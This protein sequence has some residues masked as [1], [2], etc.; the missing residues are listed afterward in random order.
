MLSIAQHGYAEHGCEYSELFLE[1]TDN[2]ITMKFKF[3]LF[4]WPGFLFFLTLN[5]FTACISL[6]PKKVATEEESFWSL[7][8]KGDTEGAKNLFLGKE[9]IDTVDKDGRTPLHAACDM[10]DSGLALFLVSLGADTGKKDRSGRYPLD[11]AMLMG[12]QEMVAVL[13]QAGANILAKGSLSLSPFEFALDGRQHLLAALLNNNNID[14]IDDGQRSLLQIAVIKGNLDAVNLLLEKG[15]RLDHRDLAEK[16][17]LD[18]AF[19][20]SDSQKHAEIA[21]RLILAG[22]TSKDKNFSWFIPA[23]RSANYNV[24]LD[25]SLTPIHFAARYGYTGYIRFLISG[26]ADIKAKTASGSTAL[27]EALRAGKIPAAQILID[28]GSEINARDA[29]GN[30]ALHI[31]MPQG[32]REDGMRLLLNSGADPDIKDGFG[33]SPLHIAI[34]LNMHASIVR[35]LLEKGADLNVRNSAGQSPL[36]MAIEQE[37]EQI[38]DILVSRGADIF[39]TDI[40]GVTPFDIAIFKSA[41]LTEKLLGATNINAS[42]NK[43]NTLLHIALAAHAPTDIIRLLIDRGITISARNKEG[44]TA[45]HIAVRDNLKDSG[46]LL[47]VRGADLFANNA[48][49]ISPLYLAAYAQAG[50]PEWFLNTVSMEARDGQGNSILHYIANYRRNNLI[51]LIIQK[52]INVEI[53]NAT[54]ETP[55][56][57]AVKGDSPS[58]VQTLIDNGADPLARDALGNTALHAA[59][60]WNVKGAIDSL[61]QAKI[62]INARNMSGKTALHEAVRLGIA[63]IEIVLENFGADVDARDSQGNSPL[64]EAIQA[65]Q[66]ASIE[67]LLNQGSNPSMRNSRGD[68]PLHIAVGMGRQDICTLLLAKAASIHSKNANGVSPFTLAII[69][70][71]GLAT[72]LLTKDRIFQSDDNGN[73]PLHLLILEKASVDLIKKVAKLGIR[74]S[75]QDAQGKTAIRLAVE[76]NLLEQTQALSAIGSNFFTLAEDGQSALSLVLKKDLNWL[77]ALFLEGKIKAK[78]ELG[79]TALHYAAYLGNEAQISYLLDAGAEKNARNVSG[80]TPADLARRWK[81]TANEAVL[82]KK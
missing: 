49:G 24:R 69:A 53:K 54:G 20:Y 1:Y 21:E 26:G 46:E 19:Q 9:N 79:N 42:D 12:N 58:T 61:L 16:T 64:H 35:L 72:V 43:G 27:H 78:D 31:V 22:A 59:V 62:D 4:F 44:E 41:K 40:Q 67:R 50:F 74:V 15:A 37:R 52:G 82:L 13:A 48:E 17:A 63:D 65:G 25:D 76:K 8:E 14:S 81:K 11:I 57:S 71:Q 3:S 6:P 56:F 75:D 23:V 32:T 45:L 70:N 33:D 18:N 38:V 73:S 39:V 7:L 28:A 36:H 10:E 66:I 2:I 47:L 5:F 34:R 29:K 51:P 30:T 55:L 68:T 80:E 60:R 77:K